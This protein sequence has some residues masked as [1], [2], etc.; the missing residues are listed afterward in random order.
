MKTGMLGV[1][2]LFSSWVVETAVLAQAVNLTNPPSKATVELQSFENKNTSP[3]GAKWAFLK[4]PDGPLSDTI[5]NGLTHQRARTL[6]ER[7]QITVT[8]IGRETPSDTTLRGL[9][10]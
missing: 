5:S 1:L 6:K 4:D 9:S 2:L 3:L 10:N 7:E 8:G